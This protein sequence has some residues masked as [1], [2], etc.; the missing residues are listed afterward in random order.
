MGVIAR[1]GTILL[2]NKL[3]TTTD[4]DM[5]HL[6]ASKVMK[7]LWTPLWRQTQSFWQQ[8]VNDEPWDEDLDWET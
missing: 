5:D 1:V 4:K 7:A 6:L 2:Q 3:Y 8:A